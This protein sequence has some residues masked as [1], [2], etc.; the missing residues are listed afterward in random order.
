ML[1]ISCVSE[2]DRGLNL[3]RV[4]VLSKLCTFEVE[5]PVSSPMGF[6]FPENGPNPGFGAMPRGLNPRSLRPMVPGSTSWTTHTWELD[7][8]AKNKTNLS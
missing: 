7:Y 2:Y 1:K 8:H 6:E 4:N 3:F 5:F